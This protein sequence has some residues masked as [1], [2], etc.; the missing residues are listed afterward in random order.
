MK[1]ALDFGCG[2]GRLLPPLAEH[3]QTVHAIDVS[4]DMIELARSNTYDIDNIKFHLELDSVKD[5]LDF[6]NS[7]I[8]FQHIHPTQGMLII[9]KLMSMLRSGGV[10]ALHVTT[11]DSR[12]IRAIANWAR[13]RIT[14]LH[15]IYNLVRGR[16]V[17]EP[18]TEMNKYIV[19]D[20]LEMGKKYGFEG[21]YVKSIDQNGHRGVLIFAQKN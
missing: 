16:P 7:F 17:S 2:V 11:G 19:F 12:P 8:V 5:E 3:F 20:I 21:A 14:P 13:Y 1:E 4:P 15:W 10:M 6:I 9:Q 18:I